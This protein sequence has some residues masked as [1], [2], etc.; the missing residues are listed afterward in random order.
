M[1]GILLF[2]QSVCAQNLSD[3]SDLPLKYEMRG[4]WIAS[5]GN[6]DWP[7]KKNLSVEQQKAEFIRIAQAQRNLGMNALFV[8]VRPAADAFYPSQYDPWSEYLTG[9][10][11]QVPSPFYD[12]LLFMI[13]ETHKL[14]MEFHAWI[15][16]YRSV[17]D[18]NNSS[19][20]ENHVT[21]LHPEWFVTYGKSKIF[22]PGLPESIKYVSG[23]VR[24]ILNRYDVDGIHMDDYFYPY[25]EAGK[26]FHDE[27]AYQKYGKG[28]SLANWR[29]ANCDS[30][31]KAIH[32]T[33][34]DTKPMVKFGVSPFGVYRN[35][36]AAVPDGSN[37]HATTN[38]DDLY[39]DI[40]LWLQQGWVDYVAPQLYWHIG[41]PR[42]DYATLIQW[43]SQHRYGK[44][45]YIG[46]G[47]YKVRE[48]P[49]A[50]WRNANELPAHILLAHK[51]GNEVQGSIFFSSKDVL[52]NPNGWADSLKNHY[53][54]KPAIVPPMPWVD[55]TLPD[56]PE[57]SATIDRYKQISFSA[58]LAPT[59]SQQVVSQF[60]VY[61]AID[62]ARLGLSP[63]Q[64]VALAPQEENITFS[65][66][67]WNV[68]ANV[69]R[70]FVAVSS[71]DRENNES[72]LSNFIVIERTGNNNWQ[73][74][75]GH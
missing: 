75:E 16:P 66:K 1:A 56:A 36:S 37:T 67:T 63:D 60:I 65:P 25:P 46:E 53:F 45:L 64:I 40:L 24:D 29:R 69:Q 38:Y 21:K 23:V 42:A 59:N 31:I 30:I 52:A 57:L 19:V 47:I 68:P 72:D 15:N 34:L 74:V 22:N 48:E 28:L 8:Q 3:T 70:V 7:S 2:H 43:W 61:Y 44:H 9:K 17:M 20:A 39:A 33:V 27:A 50:A 71:L 26:P 35:K 13:A 11:G 41:N 4:V 12:P 55:D 6:I 5:V 51:L 14:G 58:S 62:P 73:V 18:V 54:R 10:Q 49:N 32:E